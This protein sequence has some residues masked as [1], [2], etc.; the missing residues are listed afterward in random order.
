MSAAM[1]CT[2]EDWFLQLAMLLQ[3]HPHLGAAAD[4]AGMTRA[5]AWGLWCYVSRLAQG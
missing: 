3:R 1:N 5:E 2:A 4:L